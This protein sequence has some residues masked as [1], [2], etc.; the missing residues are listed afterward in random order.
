MNS[1][2]W[3]AIGSAL[4]GIGRFWMSG[5]VLRL[6]PVAFPWGTLLINVLGSFVIGLF[7]SLT[8]MDG[9][10]PLVGT[11]AGITI[12][13]FVMIG[14]CGGFTTFSSFSLQTLILMQDHRWLE[15]GLNILASVAICLIAVSL[16]DLFG[17]LLQR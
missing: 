16:G 8:E 9:R 7:G 17:T 5:A 1:Y 3:I 15:A 13:Q 4:G 2:L 10:Y 11:P 6:L 14:L 12:R